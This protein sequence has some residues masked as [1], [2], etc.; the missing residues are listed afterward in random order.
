M[1][2]QQIPELIGFRIN[3]GKYPT[4][5]VFQPLTFQIYLKTLSKDTEPFASATLLL[6]TSN[7]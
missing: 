1:I 4:K 6:I 2:V 3:L 7:G 5:N